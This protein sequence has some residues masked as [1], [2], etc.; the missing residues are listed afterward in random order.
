VLKSFKSGITFL[1]AYGPALLIKI[2]AIVKVRMKHTLHEGFPVIVEI[3]VY[4]GDQDTFHHVNNVTY[5]RY[6]EHARIAYLDRVRTWDFLERTGTGPIMASTHC[7]FCAPLTYPDVVSVGARVA[8]IGHDRFTMKYR[9][10]SH[11]LSKI[12]AEG[13]AMLVYYDYRNNVKVP[14]PEEMKQNIHDLE[15][16]SKRGLT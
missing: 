10:V 11:R 9:V 7:R 3:P 2:F 16:E 12:A 15:A 1:F 6:F 5:F 4:W 8:D 14:I 13:D